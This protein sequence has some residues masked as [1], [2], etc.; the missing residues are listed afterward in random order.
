MNNYEKDPLL[1]QQIGEYLKE[2]GLDNP[3][4]N[5]IDKSKV[6]TSIAELISGLGVDLNDDSIAKTPERVAKFFINELFYG[7]DYANFP[8]I[9]FN[10]NR[11]GYQDPVISNKITFNSTCEHHLVTISGQALIGYVPNKQVVGLSKLNRIVDFFARRPQV[12]ERATLQIFHALQK[13]LNTE[14]VAVVIKATHHCITMRGVFD[15]NVENITYKFGGDFKSADAKRD[16]LDLIKE[17]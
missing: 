16:L 3:I 14:N 9:T 10:P 12:Q 17:K 15:Q 6:C 7:L 1:G 4:K 13:I 11:Y 2:L 8:K 5:P